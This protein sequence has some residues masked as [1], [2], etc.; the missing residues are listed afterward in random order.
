[1][2][3]KKRWVMSI[4]RF[5]AVFGVDMRVVLAVVG[6]A[7]LMARGMELDPA[8]YA[9]P[10][11]PLPAFNDLIANVTKAQTV[12]RTRVVGAAA[13]R[14]G[15]LGALVGGMESERLY[16]QSLAD[17]DRAHA[18]QIIQNAGLVV[19]GSPG[20]TKL[21]LVLRPG[22]QPGSVVCDA[23]VGML[24]GA[25]AKH[26]YAARFYGWQYTVDGGKTFVTSPTT[27]TGKTLLTGLPL[28]IEIGVRVNVTIS[29]VTTDWSDVATIML[30]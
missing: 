6:R 19:A 2:T 16:I 29:G 14:D 30:H 8:T 20:R 22:P 5:R 25:G 3:R 17:A 1:V 24:V 10:S 11:P 15:H 12:V 28:L 18:V 13:T 23:N 9:K 4:G 27:G 21:L 26:P 7:E